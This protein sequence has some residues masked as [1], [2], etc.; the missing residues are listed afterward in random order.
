MKLFAYLILLAI[1]AMPTAALADD[2]E[3]TFSSTWDDVEHSWTFHDVEYGEVPSVTIETDANEGYTIATQLDLTDGFVTMAFLIY[4]VSMKEG[5]RDSTQVVSKSRVISSPKI[6]T[7]LGEDALFRSGNET[8][9]IEVSAVYITT[10]E[11]EGE[12]EVEETVEE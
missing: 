6:R 4:E 8:G 5:R 11:D 12:E 2:L 7:V 3:V 10:N 1:L 9:H